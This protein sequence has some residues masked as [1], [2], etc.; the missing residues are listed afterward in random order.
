MTHMFIRITLGYFVDVDHTEMHFCLL[1]KHF[2]LYIQ[3]AALKNTPV[4]K[5]LFA[6]RRL[7]Y[8]KTRL[9]GD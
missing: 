5:T 6:T 7:D 1:A 9:L 4:E 2:S 8:M 3:K